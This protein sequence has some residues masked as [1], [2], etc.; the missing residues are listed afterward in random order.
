MSVISEICPN[1]GCRVPPDAPANLCP[2]CLVK[3]WFSQ[4]AALT[5]PEVGRGDTLH[6]VI[7]E[8]APLPKSPPKRLGS[9]ELLELIARG[10]MGVVYKAR[11]TMCENSHPDGQRPIRS[12]LSARDIAEAIISGLGESGQTSGAFQFTP[13]PAGRSDGRDGERV[14]S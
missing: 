8:D 9:Y 3:G 12:E 4:E 13:R 7:P 6:I 10:G 2:A 14:A 1:C 5:K 11:H